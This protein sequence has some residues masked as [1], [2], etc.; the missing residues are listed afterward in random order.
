MQRAVSIP[1]KSAW[2]QA[3]VR[4]QGHRRARD[5]IAVYS[6]VYPLLGCACA[7]LASPGVRGIT[8]FANREE[9]E[10]EGDTEAP[11]TQEEERA[12]HLQPSRKRVLA[13]GADLL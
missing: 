8:P 6:H 9:E 10:E 12:G 5:G 3:T 13:H 11:Q 2:G 4:R 1:T 7:G